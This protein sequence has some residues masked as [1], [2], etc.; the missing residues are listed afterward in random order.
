MFHL[1]KSTWKS[2]IITLLKALNRAMKIILRC[3]QR[4]SLNTCSKNI[5][6]T[7]KNNCFLSLAESLMYRWDIYC[8]AGNWCFVCILYHT[9]RAQWTFVACICH[10]FTR[11][12]RRLFVCGGDVP[13]HVRTSLYNPLFLTNINLLQL[14]NY[15][16]L[17]SK[18]CCMVE[19]SIMYVINQ[20]PILVYKLFI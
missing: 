3:K 14:S 2:W 1:V 4:N 15:L 17:I 5:S 20:L 8:T 11:T 13:H 12:K 18:K 6:L 7:W 9:C 16:L 19:T 10:S